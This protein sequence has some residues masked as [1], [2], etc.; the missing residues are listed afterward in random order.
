MSKD[1]KGRFLKIVSKKTEEITSEVASEGVGEI[2]LNIVLLK[3][4]NSK[5]LLRQSENG[6]QEY[7]FQCPKPHING[8][9]VIKEVLSCKRPKALSKVKKKKNQLKRTT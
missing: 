9:P 7:I 4:E 8:L 1:K 6:V 3:F 2:S 5:N